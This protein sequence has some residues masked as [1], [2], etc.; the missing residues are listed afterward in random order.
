MTRLMCH[1]N[2]VEWESF[3]EELYAAESESAEE[4]LDD[5]P[6]LDQE[7]ETD[8]RRVASND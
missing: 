7:R 6:A 2:E 3:N 8:P 4:S 5:A 1:Y